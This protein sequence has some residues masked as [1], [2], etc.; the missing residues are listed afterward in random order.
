[1]TMDRR[2]RSQELANKLQASREPDAVAIK[3]LLVLQF[4]EIKAGLVSAEGDDIL[5][6]QG[7]A[8][9]I[10]RLLEL[11]TRAPLPSKE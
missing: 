10:E 3:E 2:Q 7:G 9:A 1:M 6:R 11:L 8:R 5:R 4:E